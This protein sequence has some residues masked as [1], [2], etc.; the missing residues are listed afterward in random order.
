LLGG[1]AAPVDDTSE[2]A[3]VLKII[4]QHASHRTVNRQ[5][6]SLAP[7]AENLER[8]RRGLGIV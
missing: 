8:L 1:R 6:G 4:E 2:A 3:P 5:N 7:R